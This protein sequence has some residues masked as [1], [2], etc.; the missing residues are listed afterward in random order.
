MAEKLSAYPALGL[1][2][3]AAKARELGLVDRWLLAAI[4]AGLVLGA[5]GMGWGRYDCLNVDSMAFRTIFSGDRPP[6]HPG[7][8]LKP[9]FYTYV[10]HIAARLPAQAI[11]GAIVW[12]GGKVRDDLYFRLRL[13]LGR[14][15][16]LAMFAGCTVMIFALCRAFFGSVAARAAA[17]LFATTAGFVV[18][19]VF[20]TT[21]LALLF[22]MLA[23]FC[24]AAAIVRK[25]SVGVSVAAGLL[26]GLAAATKY[27]GLAV[28]A[29]L[30]L[31]HLLASRGNPL[32]ACLR[33]PAAWLC[34]LAVPVG[35]VLG[36]PYAVFD[37]P[38]F[39]ADFL[40]NYHTTP[41]YGGI[42]E[43][44][45]YGKF[46]ATFPEIFGWPGTFFL[47]VGFLLGLVALAR[48]DRGGDGWKLVLLALAVVALYYWKIGAFP[49]M[50]TR[51]VL[52]VAPF[53]VLMAASGFALLF[54]WRRTASV[55]LGGVVA[56]NLVCGWWVGEL[57][58]SDP[59]MALIPVV[60]AHSEGKTRVEM[61]KSIP[62]LHK[63]AGEDIVKIE[64]PSAI[65]RGQLFDEIF[66]DREDMQRFRERWQQSDGLEWF[67]PEARAKRKTDMIVWSE[68]DVE[69][70][71]RPFFEALLAP[72]SAYEVVFDA[73][74]ARRPSWVYPSRPEFVPNRAVVLVKRP[75]P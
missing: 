60:A 21:D 56:Y 37:W 48:R 67:Q 63:L 17:L 13:F 2:W 59:R 5:Q 74:S 23:S 45:G 6:G 39:S 4:A 46:L 15:V 40:Y 66:A 55:L 1:R 35:F 57:F 14:A 70:P 65:R 43:G 29:A 12:G 54:H 10:N 11:S 38:K 25:P 64:L 20:L 73:A 72:D 32:L 71:V 69:L 30:P 51:F 26:A 18:Y 42:T 62:L 16:N 44:T 9:P 61:S 41:V 28:A 68:N 19:Q 36:N 27:N 50:Q 58:R 8:F 7:T 47:A 31:A 52:P 49:R 33:R 3:L 22:M 53:V 75:A 34:G 24:G